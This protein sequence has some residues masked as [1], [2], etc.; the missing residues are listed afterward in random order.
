ML[1][2]FAILVLI[3]LLS[4]FVAPLARSEAKPSTTTFVLAYHKSD[5]PEPQALSKELQTAGEI[6]K[7]RLESL[8]VAFNLTCDQ[9]TIT[10]NVASTAPEVMSSVRHELLRAGRLEF[11]RVHPDSLTTQG[12]T[13]SAPPDGF[14]ILFQESRSAGRDYR[15]ALWVKLHSEL[16]PRTIQQASHTRTIHGQYEV[17][18]EFT[19]KGRAQFAALT[20]ALAEERKLD[21]RPRRLAIVLDGQ[22]LA[23]PV[24]VEPITGGRAVITGKFAER[25]AL[26]LCNLVMQPLLLPSIIEQR[27]N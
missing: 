14:E 21:D 5:T 11:R 25:E 24:V 17:E 7:M 23:A 26:E 27:S 3:Q 12:A 1:S 13:G 22:L 19:E 10:I 8:G 16:S 18:I 15:E 20:Q 2:R 9:G 4:C 6:F